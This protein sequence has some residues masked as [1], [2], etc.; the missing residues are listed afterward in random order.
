VIPA[1]DPFA[2]DPGWDGELMALPIEIAEE[3]GRLRREISDEL[4]RLGDLEKA[5]ESVAGKLHVKPQV[6]RE[7]VDELNEHI[8]RGLPVPTDKLIVMEGYGNYLVVHSCFGETVNATLACIFDAVLSDRDMITGW[9][10]D[11]FRILIEVPRKV[12]PRDLEKLPAELFGLSDDA[13]EKA[14]SEYLEARFPFPE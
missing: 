9:W 5:T 14:F 10:H 7:I 13:V 6:L 2:V 1:E 4:K 8:K 11:A 3:S 12:E